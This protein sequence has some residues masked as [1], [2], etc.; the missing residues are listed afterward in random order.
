MK[1]RHR[2]PERGSAS[3]LMVGLL[4]VVVV[5]GAAAALIGGYALAYHRARSAADLAALSGAVAE[6]GRP[7]CV[8]ADRIARA[9]RVRL[10][11]C[12]QV[13]DQVD[14]VLTVRVAAA[15]QS[16]LPGLPDEVEA[17]AHAG[18]AGSS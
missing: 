13:G 9:N 15:V 8:D 10:A 18:P 2:R 4:S 3:V 7:A 12:D 6:Q 17:E 11:D 5:L 16:R 14:F 1:S